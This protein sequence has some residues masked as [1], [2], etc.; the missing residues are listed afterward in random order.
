[1]HKKLS[2]FQSIPLGVGS[3][4][5][6]GILFLPSMTYKVSGPDVLI[7]W[8]LIIGLCVPGIIFFHEMVQKLRPE[9]SNLNGLIELGLGKDIG[10]SVGLI[11][12]GTVI[13]GMP[14]AAIVAGSYCA[15]F[16]EISYLKQVVSFSILTIALLINFF[17]LRTAS[18]I[19]LVISGL[20]LFFGFYLLQGSVQKFEAYKVLQ[21]DFNINNIYSGSVLAFW[22]FAGF[23]NLT[24]LYSNFQ[25]PRRDLLITIIVSIIL[26][27]AIYLGLVA[28]YAAIVPYYEIKQTTGLMQ[29][30][31]F[32]GGEKLGS[33]IVLFAITAVLINLL[34]WTSGI[35]ELM[36]VISRE[37][38]IPV[39]LS[40]SPRR[41]LFLLGTLFYFSLIIGLM[42][43]DVFEKVLVIV[44]TNFLLIYLL[45]I[46]SY[47]LQS[48]N[49][50]KRILAFMLAVILLATISSSSYLLI[51]PFLLFL[52]SF[53][54]SRRA[55]LT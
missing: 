37:N 35:I 51:Y 33:I 44:S 36:I 39:K 50:F 46:L 26:C 21:P 40:E 1:M 42:S 14:A 20:L 49:V 38:I 22:A 23:E 13:F 7:S 15:D 10:N 31:S 52:V 47:I 9:S 32:V 27:G 55:C 6:S 43:P 12:L 30:A 4:I 48:T 34:S 28:N 54:R 5:G 29:L 8:L 3:I 45:I 18:W 25:N 41:C 24:F 19:S 2:L 11:L 53:F 17:G 16:F